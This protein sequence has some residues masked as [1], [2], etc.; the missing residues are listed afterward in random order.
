MTRLLLD[1][2]VFGHDPSGGSKL[3]LNEH[4]TSVP[5]SVTRG[6][7]LDLISTTPWAGQRL[8]ALHPECPHPEGIVEQ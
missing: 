4:K 2:G 3:T 5:P 8:S 1:S 7:N 6:S